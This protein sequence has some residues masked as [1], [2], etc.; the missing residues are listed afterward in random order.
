MSRFVA[1]LSQAIFIGSKSKFV[2]SETVYNNT[3][4]I[5][6]YALLSSFNYFVSF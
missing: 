1:R 6:F 3:N 2:Y 5:P 4:N